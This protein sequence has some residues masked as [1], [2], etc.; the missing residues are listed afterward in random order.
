MISTQNET[1]LHHALK[2]LY[3]KQT[4][5]ATE[6]LLEGKICDVLTK[7]GGIIEI[8]TA[9]V[10]KLASKVASLIDAHPVKIVYP[11]VTQKIIQKVDKYG[12]V[13]SS[14][15]SPKKLTIYSIFRE[16]TGLYPW[17][18]HANFT[19]EALPVTA[20]EIRVIT[21]EPVQ[22]ANNR[23]RHL[24]TWYKKDKE[25]VSYDKPFVFNTPDDYLALL[26]FERGEE[27]TVSD[28]KRS[29][30]KTV[31]KSS[32]D[33]DAPLMLWVLTK[34]EL[35]TQTRTEGRKRVYRIV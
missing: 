16:V 27:F 10:S 28:V 11:F 18:F 20:R 15:K 19:L 34:C 22:S 31:S 32:A 7:Q 1:K 3:A 35:I 13:V 24:R 8:Q 9:N 23:R 26:P 4:G 5:G 14:K 33:R 12:T 30:M 17:L 6:Q 2:I 25:L 21:D 29:L